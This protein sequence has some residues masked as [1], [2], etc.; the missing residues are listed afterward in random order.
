VS[1]QSSGRSLSDLERSV[2]AHLLSVP[3]DGAAEL[4]EQLAVAIVT[5]QWKPQGSPSFDI[6]VPDA[7]RISPTSDGVAPLNAYVNNEEGEYLGELMLW[8]KD[9]KLAGLEYAWVTEGRPSCL[10]QVS[11]IQVSSRYS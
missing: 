2:I 9:G 5:R 1:T 3:F 7:A 6:S 10:P 11:L 8:I 4:R